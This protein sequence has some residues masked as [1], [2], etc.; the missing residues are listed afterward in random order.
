MYDKEKIYDR[1]SRYRLKGSVVMDAPLARETSFGIGGPADILAVPDNIAEAVRIVKLCNREKIP[2]TILGRGANLLVKDRGVRGIVMKLGG[3]CGMRRERDSIF[4]GAG[5]K[6]GDV[7]EYA[8]DEGLTGLEFAYGIPGTVG[9]AVCM[10][11][12][13]YGG[14]MKDVVARSVIMDKKG[15]IG[16]LDKSGHKFS[17]RKSA[18][19]ENECII[20]ETEF[21]LE[22]SEKDEI[23]G[24]MEANMDKRKATQPLEFPSA[25]SVF[26]RPAVDGVYVGPMIEKCGLKGLRVG[27]AEVSEKHAGFII[28]RGG[29]TADDVLSLIRRIQDEVAKRFAVDLAL[30][31]RVIGE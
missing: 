14:E 31:I 15:S 4:A 8:R 27:G 17:Y 19:Q 3:I 21:L 2:L 30:E 26:R 6:L 29:A 12:G 20:L 13:A 23:S 28:N 10:N 5:A 1:I 11:A 18:F 24:K 25:G 22:T 7:C 16:L 9:G